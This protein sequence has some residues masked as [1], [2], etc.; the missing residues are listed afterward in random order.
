MR[1]K[2]MD[3]GVRALVDVDRRAHQQ[4]AVTTYVFDMSRPHDIRYD[5]FPPLP[6]DTAAQLVLKQLQERGYRNSQAPQA[7]YSP[8]SR[9]QGYSVA[10]QY[11]APYPGGQG[12]PQD[13][14]FSTGPPGAYPFGVPGYGAPTTDQPQ[15]LQ[16]IIRG[17]QHPGAAPAAPGALPSAH[18]PQGYGLPSHPFASAGA[19]MPGTNGPAGYGPT[20]GG[21][22]TQ[23][24]VDSIMANLAR[25]RG[26]P[27]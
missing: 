15:N 4:G 6:V 14:S 3:E 22:T 13:A 19:A 5:Q 27:V 25:L 18:S 8:Y 10:P 7:A 20:L 23:Q 21:P 12:S 16:D 2:A 1:R 26:G 9:S 24:S 11:Q 17:L